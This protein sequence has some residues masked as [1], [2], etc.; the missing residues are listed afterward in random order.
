LFGVLFFFGAFL[1]DLS[2][3]PA[4]TN[5]LALHK[6]PQ[7]FLSPTLIFFGLFLA[8]YPEFD[9]ELV[10]WSRGMYTMSFYIFPADAEVPR[11]YSVIGLIFIALGIHFSTI[12]KDLLSNKYLLWLGKNSFAVYLLHGSFIRTLFVWMQFGIHLPPDNV[13][14]QGVHTP[15]E[16][17]QPGGRLLW[18]F[19]L[20]IW[21]VML[22][23]AANYWTRYVDTWCAKLTKRMEDYCF[24]DAHTGKPAVEKEHLSP[25]PR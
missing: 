21:F 4:H 2:Q 8:S 3:H 24:E 18:Y 6:W 13:D 1:C 9:G 20:P 5:W 12:T 25:L 19:W 16:K 15:G 11:F 14:E 23:T 7:R 10:G 22:Y 17:L